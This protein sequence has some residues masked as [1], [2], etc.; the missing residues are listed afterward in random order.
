M[1]IVKKYT[2]PISVDSYGDFHAT[3]NE[4]YGMERKIV[5]VFK[6]LEK[7]KRFDY[8]ELLKINKYGNLNIDQIRKYAKKDNTPYVRFD[9]VYHPE[10]G[11]VDREIIR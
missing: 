7:D 6:L 2:D 11:F 3:F 5:N 9:K 8:G 4:Q 10:Y 1:M